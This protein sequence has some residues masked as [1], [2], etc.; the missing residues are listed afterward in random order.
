M[1]GR[2]LF[3]T[4]SITVQGEPVF[5]AYIPF[6]DE[7]GLCLARI[8]MAERT[9]DFLVETRAAS[10]LVCRSGRLAFIALRCLRHGVYREPPTPNAG[11]WNSNTWL[12]SARCRL[13]SPTKFAILWALSRA[14]RKLLAE[15]H[16]TQDSDLV[17]PIL[18]ETSR[19]EGLVKD[20]LLYGRPAQPSFQSWT[21][22]GLRRRCVPMR[23]RQ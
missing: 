11:N 6:H 22:D 1:E 18:S 21:A 9:A 3:Q 15:R 4:E 17:A 23:S 8:D 14:L 7:R 5:R 12:T 10:S 19:L 20:L 13:Y 2:E 16:K